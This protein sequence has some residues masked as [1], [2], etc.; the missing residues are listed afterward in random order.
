MRLVDL[1]ASRRFLGKDL[2]G[3]MLYLKIEQRDVLQQVKLEGRAPFA[4][5]K[6]KI[7]DKMDDFLHVC[8][9]LKAMLSQELKEVQ[10]DEEPDAWWLDPGVLCFT[11]R[12]VA[13][14][15]KTEESFT[16][17]VKRVK[18]R[19]R[20]EGSLVVRLHLPADFT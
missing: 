17:A 18:E 12:G 10:F 1:T 2:E 11:L 7:A 3:T 4:S 15:V 13:T 5:M 8:E 16:A 9:I 6:Q 19:A 14:S 20:D